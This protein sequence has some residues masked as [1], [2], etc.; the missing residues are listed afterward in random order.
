MSVMISD[1]LSRKSEMGTLLQGNP[2]L[3]ISPE[4]KKW[5]HVVTEQSTIWTKDSVPAET[6]HLR[7][8]ACKT[9]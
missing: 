3:T 6:E 5:I 4:A 1:T 9:S 7:K 2:K 8:R